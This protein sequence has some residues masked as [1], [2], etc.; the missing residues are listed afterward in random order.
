MTSFRV[1]AERQDRGARGRLLKVSIIHRLPHDVEERFFR[2][3]RNLLIV[4][5]L[6]CFATTPGPII[7]LMRDPRDLASAIKQLRGD[8][9]QR[10]VAAKAEVDPSTWSL[11]EAGD[12][13]PRTQ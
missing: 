2:F 10:E 3:R 5:S 11:Y 7:S 9:S 4:L 13:G 8:R 12:R 1:D 6:D